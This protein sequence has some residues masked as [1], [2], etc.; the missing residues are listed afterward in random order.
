MHFIRNHTNSYIAVKAIQGLSI[1][2][3]VEPD[4]CLI[5]LSSLSAEINNYHTTQRSKE[6]FIAE[7]TSVPGHLSRDFIRK[8]VKGKIIKLSSFKGKYVLLDFWASW[9]IPCRKLTKS[10][11]NIY[12]KYSS[13]GLVVMA[14]SCDSKYEAWHNAIRTDGIR[15]F[16]NILSFTDIDMNFLK[17]HDKVGDASFEGELRKQFNL[18]PIPAEILIDKEGIIL[19]RYGATEKQT[20]DMLDKKLTEIF[21][22]FKKP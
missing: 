11:K 10:I 12:S 14:I 16:I 1:Y 5:L 19:G 9:C 8:D 22:G 17:T 7:S 20:L 2:E 3:K 15:S 4:S 21:N 6:A 13:K 18:M